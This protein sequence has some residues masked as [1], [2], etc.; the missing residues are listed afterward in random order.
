MD[1]YLEIDLRKIIKNI[2]SKWY[3]VVIPAAVIGIA[4]FLYSFFLLGDSYKANATVIIT[5]PRYVAN[6]VDSFQTDDPP[7]PSASAIKSLASSDEVILQLFDLWETEEKSEKTKKAFR[8]KLSIEASDSDMLYTLSVEDKNAQEAAKLANAWA[9]LVVDKVNADFF[10]YDAEMITLFEAQLSE[11]KSK[12]ESAETVLINFIEDDQRALLSDRLSAIKADQSQTF[13]K[14]GLL[15]E[16][17]F[18]AQGLLAQLE[19]EADTAQ[20]DN[21]YRLSYL[22]L[23]SQLYSSGTD[24]ML[25]SPMDSINVSSLELQ[26]QYDL[27]FMTVSEFRLMLENWIATIDDQIAQLESEEDSYIAAINQLEAEIRSLDYQENLLEADVST[28]TNTYK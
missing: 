27:D 11:S 5:N 26:N 28:Y 9:D 21:S 13:S 3:W 16:A 15:K 4:V 7:K 19:T 2:L 23:Q 1:D 25:E 6:F 12:M 14:Q 10:S 18:N 17:K 22:L 20:V 8:E 24:I